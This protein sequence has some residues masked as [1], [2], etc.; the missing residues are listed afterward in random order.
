MPQTR[1]SKLTRPLLRPSFDY[2]FLLGVELNSVAPLA[3]YEHTRNKDH[4]FRVFRFVSFCVLSR[5]SFS[6][7]PNLIGFDLEKESLSLHSL[8]VTFACP[9]DRFDFRDLGHGH[10]P[11]RLVTRYALLFIDFDHDDGGSFLPASFL[12]R[13]L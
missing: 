9:L 11:P 12:Q 10:V 3:Y 1:E 2:D 13:A 6:I 8:V 7:C 4:E 5:I